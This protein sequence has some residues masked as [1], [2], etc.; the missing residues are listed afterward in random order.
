MKWELCLVSKP[1]FP[2]VQALVEKYRKRL[3]RYNRVEAAYFR[4]EDRLLHHLKKTEGF[5]IVLD[6]K[7][8]SLTTRELTIKVLEWQ[9]GSFQTV[10]LCVGGAYG[11]SDELRARADL[12]LRLSK[13]TLPGDLAW[14]ILWE[15]LFRAFS[16]IHKTGYHHG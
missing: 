5:T 6:E 14:L 16:I 3:I 13:M 1:N 8:L 15:Q 11:F 4:D 10:R 2:E 9:R 7:G 12:L